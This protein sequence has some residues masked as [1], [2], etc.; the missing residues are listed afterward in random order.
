L[1]YFSGKSLSS[2]ERILEFFLKLQINLQ[3]RKI[4]AFGTKFRGAL[5]FRNGSH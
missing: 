5:Y 1:I 4:F 2:S 3:Y